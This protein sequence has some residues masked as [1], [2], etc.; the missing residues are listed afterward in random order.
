[1]QNSLEQKMFGYIIGWQQSGLSQKAWCFKHRISYAAF[2]YWYKKFRDHQSEKT[3][4]PARGFVKLMV[5]DKLSDT[6]WCELVI[7]PNKKL[8]FHQPL[9]IDFIRSLLD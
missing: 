4:S 5:Q 9:N 7:S 8:V 6:P 3:V 2:H 1:M